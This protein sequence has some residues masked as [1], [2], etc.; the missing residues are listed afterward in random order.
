VIINAML[1]VI[2]T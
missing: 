2:T 1:K